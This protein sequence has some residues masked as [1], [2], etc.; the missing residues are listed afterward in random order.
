MKTVE[1]YFLRPFGE[2]QLETAHVIDWLSVGLNSIVPVIWAYVDT[3]RPRETHRIVTCS[4]D[5]E[6]PYGLGKYIGTVD[7]AGKGP[8]LHVFNAFQ[9]PPTNE[10]TT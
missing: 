1:E 7:F 5:D 8:A 6:M 3:E 2:T 10:E 4:N 9:L